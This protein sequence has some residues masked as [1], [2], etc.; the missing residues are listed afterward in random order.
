LVSAAGFLCGQTL[1]AF[2]IVR[3]R[4]LDSNIYISREVI[5]HSLTLALIGGY[6]LALGIV[7]EILQVLKIS[8]DFLT[9]AFVAIAGGAAVAFMLLSEHFRWKAKGFIQ[10][11]FYRHKYDYREEWME[12]TRQLSH[13][14]TV[15]KVAARTAERILTVMWVRQV[16][17]YAKGDQPETMHLLYQI[18]YDHLPTTLTISPRTLQMLSDPK[19]QLPSAG[20]REGSLEHQR[21]LIR[22]LLPEA[23]VGHLAPLVALDAPVGLLIVGPEV[24]GKPFG[25]DD[26]DLLA[27][28]AAQAGA[29]VVNA[30]LAQ[31]TAEGRELQALARLAAFV[32][33]DL[34][35]SVGM[36][37]LLAENAPTHMHKPEFQA[38]A[39]RTLI[40]VTGRMQ[41]LLTTL[42]TSDQ[43]PAGRTTR[44]SL[45]P[46]VEAFLRDLKPQIPTR[47][48]LE[49]RLEAT[50][51][52]AIDTEQL[53]TILVNLVLNAA[54]AI[55]DEG[56]ITV[57]TRTNE[58]WVTLTVTDTGQ[59]MSADFVRDRLFRPFQT[60]KPR[61][62]GIGVYQC[63]CIARAFGGE[64][65][66]D[67]QEGVGTRMTVRLPALK[68][69]EQL[70]AGSWNK[71][72]AD[73]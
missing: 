43:R 11:H 12:F 71:A 50:P 72:E 64:I 48:V 57:E 7:A 62:L 20:R 15:A 18:G 36:L 30:R 66:V 52:I 59:G 13:A 27:A 37:S 29:M 26:T 9:G 65:T 49:T 47:I 32:A 23:P 17:V 70:A 8:L 19:A 21:K 33:H 53:R 40:D 10:A 60:T 73:G 42:R 61:G 55:P 58:G 69:S 5:Y 35:N 51:E 3:H 25:V 67:S 4:L 24:S 41:R 22:D 6:L 14:T 63:R 38:D 68:G 31:E 44:A 28:V 1:I 45:A 54:E 2:A 34:K 56:R 16:A 46:T 39:V